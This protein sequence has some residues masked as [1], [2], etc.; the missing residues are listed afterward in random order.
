MS[1]VLTPYNDAAHCPKCACTDVKTTYYPADDH[2]WLS[3]SGFAA[4]SREHLR[5]RCARCSFMWNEA[6]LDTKETADE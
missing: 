4:E 3:S 2:R 1:A 5:R 6:T